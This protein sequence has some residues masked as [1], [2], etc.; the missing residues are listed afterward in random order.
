M[1]LVAGGLFYGFTR[2]ARHTA[3]PVVDLTLFRLRCFGVGSLAGGLCRI[4]LNGAPYLLPLLL[5]IGFGLSPVTSGSIAFLTVAGALAARLVIRRALRRFGFAPV[6]TVS[7]LAGSLVLTSCIFL[8]PT[9]PHWALALYAIVFGLCRSSQFMTSNTLSYADI[10]AARL[11]QARPAW[12]DCATAHCELRRIVRRGPAR[13]GDAARH[14]ADDG[15]I[16]RSL[17]ID[18]AATVAGAAGLCSASRPK[19]GAEVEAA[20]SPGAKE[21]T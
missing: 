5:Q 17:S 2:H 1:F 11:S 6:L 16:S 10:P 8:T 14:A 19:D 3:V 9:T 15:P 13:L 4:A 20:I 7:A 12:V 21:R 18:R